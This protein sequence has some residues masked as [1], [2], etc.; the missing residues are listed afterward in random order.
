MLKSKK[1]MDADLNVGKQGN[2]HFEPRQ[3]G[4]GL[5]R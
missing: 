2:A 1:K 4:C 3:R 5:A